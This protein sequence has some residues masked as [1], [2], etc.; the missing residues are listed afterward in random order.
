LRSD[1]KATVPIGEVPR[2]GLTRGDNQ[3]CDHDLGLKEKYI[4]CG[5]VDEDTG[6]LSIMFGSSYTTSDCIV[7][8]L[9]ARW[10]ALDAQEQ[11]TT[12]RVQ[13]KMDNGP[14]SSGMR[15]Q[16]LHRMVQCAD[17]IGKPVQ[18][19]YSPPYHSKYNPI[20]RCWGILELHWNGTK[21]IHVETLLEW[22]KSMTWKGIHPVVARSRKV[23]HKGM[24]LG[25]RAMRAVEKR[26]ERHP[27]L[28]KW[29]ILIRPASAS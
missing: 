11:A 20:E 1:C 26:L 10:A 23:Y 24:S 3:A 22:A 5:I 16:F 14:E 12:E 13:I 6:E 17:H 4:P 29:D 27:E 8:A 19:L 18:L 21:L 15:T 28:P 2:G 7:E 25:K 9:E